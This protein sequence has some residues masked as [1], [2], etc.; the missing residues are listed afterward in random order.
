MQLLRSPEASEFLQWRV[1]PQ[2]NG[3]GCDIPPYKC[4]GDIPVMLLLPGIRLT[5]Q[6][7]TLLMICTGHQPQATSLQ[8]QDMTSAW[9][10]RRQACLPAEA[11]HVRTTL[12]SLSW[13]VQG[14]KKPKLRGR[15]HHYALFASLS[16]GAILLAA[17]KTSKARVA[18]VVFLTTVVLQFLISSTY[19]MYS[20]PP[21]TGERWSFMLVETT[22]KSQHSAAWL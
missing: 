2:S 4:S 20:W 12:H 17:T 9:A 3:L 1:K 16:A 18:V 7:F 14:A 13:Y 19:H 5:D 15:V 11:A 8:A 6:C 22:F 10:I 21:R